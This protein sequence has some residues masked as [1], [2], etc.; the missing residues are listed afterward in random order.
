[1]TIWSGLAKGLA[2]GGS[3]KGGVG[4]ASSN[5]AKGTAV[6]IAGAVAVAVGVERTVGRAVCNVAAGATV[7]AGRVDDRTVS[8]IV[9]VAT[10]VLV[11]LFTSWTLCG[12]ATKDGRQPEMG[13]IN[14]KSSKK[15]D[16]RIRV[17]LRSAMPDGPQYDAP[18]FPSGALRRYVR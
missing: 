12:T 11:A 1:L 3:G 15:G 4:Q 13:K 16:L 2:G 14:R 17:F 7:V 8:T 10:G 6:A 18:V 5:V 9:A